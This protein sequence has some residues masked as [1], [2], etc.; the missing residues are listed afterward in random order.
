MYMYIIHS[1]FSH[2]GSPGG[3]TGPGGP[4]GPTGPSSPCNKRSTDESKA[5]YELNFSISLSHLSV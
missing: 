5:Q 4:G 1:L 3:P 2:T